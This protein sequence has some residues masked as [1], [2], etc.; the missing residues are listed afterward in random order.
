M[1][2]EFL[3]ILKSS[4]CLKRLTSVL[5]DKAACA[6]SM[7]AVIEQSEGRLVPKRF[8][9]CAKKYRG[10]GAMVARLVHTQ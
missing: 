6:A 3:S 8:I 1:A 2:D 10:W 9:E 4:A 5:M 7:A